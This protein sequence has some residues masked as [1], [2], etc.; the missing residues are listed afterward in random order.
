MS[1]NTGKL[2]KENYCDKNGI[3]KDVEPMTECRFF[4][5]EENDNTDCIFITALGTCTSRC[6]LQSAQLQGIQL[7]SIQ[8]VSS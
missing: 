2:L 7:Y 4:L 3:C 5:S 1:G 8:Q 6:A